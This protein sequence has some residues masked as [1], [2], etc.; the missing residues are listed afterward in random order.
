MHSSYTCISFFA[1]KGPVV[2]DMV[3]QRRG[4]HVTSI[5]AAYLPD[6]RLTFAI[7]G[8]ANIVPRHGYEVHGLL[9][10]L[11]SLADWNALQKFDAGSTPSRHTVIPYKGNW[12]DD[13][14]PPVENVR[15]VEFDGQVEDEFLDSPIEVLPQSRYLELITQAMR[16]YGVDNDYIE[17]NI[18]AVPYIPKRTPE[19]YHRIPVIE[20]NHKRFS[21]S[22][23]GGNLR[24]RGSIQSHNQSSEGNSSNT[25]EHSVPTKR[26]SFSQIGGSLLQRGSIQSQTSECVGDNV[27]EQSLPTISLAKYQR[28]CAKK[29]PKD[30]DSNIMDVTFILG[31]RI[32]QIHQVDIDKVPAAKWLYKNGHGQ[33]CCALLVH[34]L[35]VDPDIPIVN[36]EEDLTPLHYRWAEDHLCMTVIEKYHCHMTKIGFLKPQQT[37]NVGGASDGNVG[38]GSGFFGVRRMSKRLSLTKPL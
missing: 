17:D 1:I 20:K 15:F 33:S 30:Q 13:A 37:T 31:D 38:E 12:V 25:N 18:L 11:A 7:G 32:F 8:M 6:F 24:Q 22:Q 19:E 28:L 4:I 23:L 29:K 14:L 5:Q 34:K 10:T 3:R 2:N 35:V 9:M 27:D 16:K 21:F 26:F 36:S